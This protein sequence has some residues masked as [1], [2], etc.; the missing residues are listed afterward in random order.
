MR[1]NI[2]ETIDDIFYEKHGRIKLLKDISLLPLLSVL[3]LEDIPTSDLFSKI[4]VSSIFISRCL[5]S[6]LL[7]GCCWL[8]C[9]N[10][11][12]CLPI[13]A[14]LELLICVNAVTFTR[15]LFHVDKAGHR[16]RPA[17]PKDWNLLQQFLK[18]TV[19]HTTG[20]ACRPHGNPHCFCEKMNK[21]CNFRRGLN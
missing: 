2:Y 17:S 13:P 3:S 18:L 20:A 5:F 9:Q 7:S 12:H 21:A 1:K 15:A 4:L 6:V 16:G 19:C 11:R 8:T 10:L 14:H